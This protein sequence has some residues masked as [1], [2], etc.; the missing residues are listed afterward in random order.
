MEVIF[1]KKLVKPYYQ[2]PL[3]EHR[4]DAVNVLREDG[5]LESNCCITIQQLRNTGA[6]GFKIP[7][8]KHSSKA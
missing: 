6:D 8:L 3:L 2:K 5:L 1:S 7:P 4:P